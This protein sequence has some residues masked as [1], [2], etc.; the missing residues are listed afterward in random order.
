MIGLSALS[1]M[2][3]VLGIGG[4]PMGLLHFAAILVAILYVT[5]SI[6][7]QEIRSSSAS[8]CC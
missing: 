5:K 8:T 4:E 7:V 6:T 3:F 2:G 1:T